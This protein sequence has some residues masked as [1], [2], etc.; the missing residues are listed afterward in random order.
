MQLLTPAF[1][2]FLV[3][4]VAVFRLVPPPAR[5]LVL[6]G[7][8]C[9]FYAA[10]DPLHLPVLLG[11]TA[12]VHR[13][14]LAV[15][16]REGRGPA[17]AVVLAVCL[18]ALLA[19]FK[20]AGGALEAWRAAPSATLSATALLLPP[21]GASYY[22]FR[23]V[24]YLLDVH[25]GRLPPERSL[26]TLA[27]YATFAPQIVSGP[28]QRTGDFL[29]QLERLAPPGPE[30]VAAALR[31][32]LLGLVKK[33]AV[34]DRLAPL[35]AVVHGDPSR[36]SSAEL[37]LAG[38]A[39][40]V[41]LY[42]DF[43][44]LTDIAL[45]AGRLLGIRGPENFD[46][47]FFAPSLPAYWRRW[48]MSLTSWLTDYLFTP[49][50]MALRRQGRAGLALALLANMVAVGIWHGLTWTYAAFGALHGVLLAG[51]A[52][53]ARQR[54]A[55]FARRPGLARIRAVT[56]PLATFHLVVLGLIV[57]RAPSIASAGTYLA[58]LVALPGGP[59][60]PR[61]RLDLAYL[62]SNA[63]QLLV[64]FAVALALEGITWAGKRPGWR[65]RFLGAAAP[66]RWALYYGAL[67]LLL[68]YGTVD[69]QQF[70]YAHF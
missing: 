2:G 47:P 56:G 17:A 39:F 10:V 18:V 31:R 34:A 21:L 25:W 48:H 13:A 54:D 67:G 60:V 59:D 52:L 11:L 61:G 53:T 37:L 62:G 40:A 1:V 42:A 41:Q 69:A 38:Y 22:T 44:G 20:L 28:I 45:G 4:W 30:E 3:V 63:R 43:S 8:S 19:G 46:L 14:A 6:L 66:L 27:A 24:G 50:R 51:A 68:L 9:L 5:R 26:A 57:F 64:T 7:G 32:I 55:F 36:F 29:G 58:R 12:L 49:L 65:E 35:V 15:G 70:I 33:V 23:L 16:G